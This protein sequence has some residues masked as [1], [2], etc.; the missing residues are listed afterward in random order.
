MS[1]LHPSRVTLVSLDEY[2]LPVPPFKTMAK[3]KSEKRDKKRKALDDPS[4]HMEDVEMVDAD[5]PKV[6]IHLSCPQT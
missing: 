1:D 2:C 3:D 4:A 5:S 6:F